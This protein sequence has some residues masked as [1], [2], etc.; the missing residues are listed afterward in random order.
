MCLA[1]ARAPGGIAHS[2]SIPR[3]DHA[4]SH[5]EQCK[6]RPDLCTRRNQSDHRGVGRRLVPLFASLGMPLGPLLTPETQRLVSFFET[7]RSTPVFL[8]R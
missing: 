5:S 8:G 3:S 7:V 1:R 4:T 2:L 6:E